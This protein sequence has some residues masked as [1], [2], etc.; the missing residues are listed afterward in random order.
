MPQL[1]GT[2]LTTAATIALRFTLPEPA[3]RMPPSKRLKLALY[4]MSMVAIIFRAEVALLLAGFCL[5]ALLRTSSLSAA[6][7]T[8]RHI[9]LPSI[10][11]AT[12]AGLTLTVTIDTFMWR[13]PRLLW[14]ELAA[15]LSNIF[16]PP[17]SQGASAWG[18]SP[19]HWYLTSALPRLLSSPLLLIYPLLPLLSSTLRTRLLH[20]NTLPLLTYLAL[21][22][23]LPHK[24]TRF[25]FPLLP[26]LT[27][28]LALAA[29]HLTTTTTLSHT[30]TLLPNHILH[31]F[32]IL[33]TL[34]TTLTSH[35]ILLPLSA[36]TYPGA[37]ALHLLHAHADTLHPPVRDLHV[38][39][40]N[41]ALQ[42][43][44]THFLEV[45]PPSKPL[46]YLPGAVDASRPELRSGG[47]R[48][49]YDKSDGTGS[50]EGMEEG[51]WGKW[52]YVVVERREDVVG[53]MEGWRWGVV[54][55]V[56]GMGRPKILS[57]KEQGED[58]GGKG[59]DGIVKLLRRMYGD[60]WFGK[61]VV[62]MYEAVK[63][64]GTKVTGGR[65]VGWETE[66]VLVVMKRSRVVDE[67]VKVVEPISRPRKEAVA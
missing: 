21:Y 19:W 35:L 51:W 13:S 18:T 64:V 16:P 8:T 56:E 43:G 40:C 2:T 3:T 57:A 38:H 62:G 20:A 42:T 61:V 32:L 12:V 34:L 9:L 10:L 50:K 29:S 25:L 24:E 15:F 4:L 48:V 31:T 1:S 47:M 59:R 60:G 7:S 52:D 6:I 53:E 67:T 39:L 33:T 22:S 28:H 54:G 14:P 46:I 41:L 49:W 58:G 11:T 27:T 37:H 55:R 5:Q 26:I 45:P 65:W 36:L 63:A 44:V 66:T 17:G 30:S 23:L